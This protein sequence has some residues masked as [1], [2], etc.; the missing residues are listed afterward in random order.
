M[1]NQSKLQT[2][3]AKV[4]QKLREYVEKTNKN[5]DELFNVVDTDGSGYL[6]ENEFLVMLRKL[7]PEI[8]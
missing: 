2:K 8:S 7:D 3:S 6:D 5:L 4:I 1:L